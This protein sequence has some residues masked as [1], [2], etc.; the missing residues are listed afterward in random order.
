M[1]GRGGS[2]VLIASDR[3]LRPESGRGPYSVAKAGVIHL[4]R[5]AAAELARDRIRVNVVCPGPTATPM[6]AELQQVAGLCEQIAT[7]PLLGRLAEP[8]E[9]AAAI[10]FC[11]VHEFMTGSTLVVDGGKTLTG[12]L[13]VRERVEDL[14]SRGS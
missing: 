7:R 14:S 10:S 12:N 2:I 1:L 8:E 6:L 3:G 11:A 13:G 9:I 5:I 4:G